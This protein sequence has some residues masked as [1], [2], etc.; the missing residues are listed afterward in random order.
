M[1]AR[2]LEWRSLLLQ[3]VLNSASASAQLAEVLH[4][5]PAKTKTQTRKILA[6]LAKASPRLAAQI[7]KVT[8]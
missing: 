6:E 2:A 3:R 5:L 1:K 8:G 4:A 7:T